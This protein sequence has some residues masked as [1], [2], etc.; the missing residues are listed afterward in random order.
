MVGRASSKKP[1]KSAS[2]HAAIN[3]D[4][5]AG[6]P[7]VPFKPQF[8]FS[9]EHQSPTFYKT[10]LET[11]EE[12]TFQALAP[13]MSTT[14]EFV[15]VEGPESQL[16]VIG[17]R[18]VEHWGT[19][20]DVYAINTQGDLAVTKRANMTCCRRMH[21]AVYY[22]NSLY[23]VGGYSEIKVL[24]ECERLNLDGDNWEP[25]DPLPKAGSCMSL[26][27]HEASE[28]LFCFGGKNPDEEFLS[29]Q[30]LNFLTLHWE[31]LP[32]QL[33]EAQKNVAAFTED[34]QVYIIVDRSLYFLDPSLDCLNLMKRL[35]TYTQSFYGSTIYRE[36]FLYCASNR[37]P[38]VRVA[39]GYLG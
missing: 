13:Y 5:Q 38:A 30:K 4:P 32:L 24:D 37:S 18:N 19:M 3:A 34:G 1:A 6:I 9:S 8:I 27:V 39:L 12:S 14:I 35:S 28:S 26:V 36:G 10:D 33:P 25:F 29:I 11:G 7:K 2:T 23:V 15:L 31:L 20:S 17:G 22:W 16:Y 21:A